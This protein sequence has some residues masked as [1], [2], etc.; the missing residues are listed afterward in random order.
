MKC[1]RCGKDKEQ[2][3]TV[4]NKE[5]SFCESTCFPCVVKCLKDH[6]KKQAEDIVKSI[7]EASE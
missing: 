5:L 4:D 2:L 6:K 3:L 1:F 7:M